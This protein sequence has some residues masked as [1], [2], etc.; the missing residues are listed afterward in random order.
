MTATPPPE[1]YEEIK[2]W[3]CREYGI[4]PDK[5]VRPFYPGG[6]YERFD[7]SDGRVVVDNPP[8]SILSKVCVF[9]REHGIPFFLFAPNLTIFSSSQRSVA[10][11]LVTD[12]EIEY[13]NGA[14][15]NTSFVTSFGDDLIRTAP[16]L[17][18][19]VNDTMERIRRKQTKQLP[20]YAYPPELLTVTRLNKLSKA[21]VDFRVK[22]SDVA[23]VRRLDS[24]VS[25]KKT[26]FGG[27]WL[28]SAAKAE[29]LKAEELKAEEPKAEEPKITWILSEN[30]N[31][32]IENL[33]K[34]RA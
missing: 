17:T 12:C 10:H 22:S 14:K 20:K 18:K 19:L 1:V 6:D 5:I 33:A 32:I 31:R 15:V 30:E 2:N 24:Q 25:M 4:D 7:Y 34:N 29:E 26:I 16:D 13:A 28:M 8:F 23:F 11:M 9:Y 21:G 27:G 3:A